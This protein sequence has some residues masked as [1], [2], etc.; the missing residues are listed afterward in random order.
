MQ[1]SAFTVD[2]PPLGD[3][4][5]GLFIARATGTGT[6][7]M[8]SAAGFQGRMAVEYFDSQGV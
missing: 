7:S 8:S 1:V 6:V 4:V 3:I 2:D 5:Y